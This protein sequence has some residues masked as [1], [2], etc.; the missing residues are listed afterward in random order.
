M[1][2]RQNGAGN[3]YIDFRHNAPCHYNE[4]HLLQIYCR[5]VVK[6]QSVAALDTLYFLAI[7]ISNYRVQFLNV[8]HLSK[9]KFHRTSFYVSVDISLLCNL[10][11]YVD[12]TKLHKCHSNHLVGC[13]SRQYDLK[14]PYVVI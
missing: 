2:R 13:K 6:T 10:N 14:F 8:I 9:I 1:V 4:I 11:L 3:P 5:V 12:H 7:A